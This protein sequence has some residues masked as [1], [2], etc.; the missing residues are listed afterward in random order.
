[1]GIAVSGL[2]LFFAAR[3]VDFQSLLW[4][5][6]EVHYWYL[7][8]VVLVT[9]FSFWIR[10]FRWHFLLQPVKHIPIGSLFSATMIG[11]M[12]NNLFPARFGE[13]VRAL[14][15]GKKA[16][17]G[18]SASFA[19][20]VLERIFDGFTILF[21]LIILVLFFPV[22]LPVWLQSAVK[23]AVVISA[24]AL[25]ILIGLRVQTARF[26]AFFQWM[27]KPLPK[28]ARDRMIHIILSFVSGLKILHDAKNILIACVVSLFVWIS[29]A[30]S[31][32]FLILAFDFHL[33]LYSAFFMQIILCLGVAIPSAPGYIGT[34]QFICVIGLALFGIEHD[35]AFSFSLLYHAGQFIPITSIGLVFFFIEGFSFGQ[36]KDSMKSYQVS[37]EEE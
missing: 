18:R 26:M 27:L 23:L 14:A 1:V 31:V 19:T 6:K 35:P 8:P 10:S 36:I 9:I 29:A 22:P 15:I 37:G 25:V 34:I 11:F 20:I 28:K 16:G 3:H 30:V 2:F 12:A 24:L 5:L 4:I 21:L 17:I 13:F 32:Y 33:P 7:V